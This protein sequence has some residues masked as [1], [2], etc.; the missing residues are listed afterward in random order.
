MSFFN[1]LDHKG[2][3]LITRLRLGLSQL[4]DNKFKHSFQDCFNPIYRCGIE[5]ERIVHYLLHCSNHYM[6]AEPFWTTS[7]LSF[8]TWKEMTLLF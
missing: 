5:T 3:K 2:V 7:S 1:C 6:K 4:R 8:I